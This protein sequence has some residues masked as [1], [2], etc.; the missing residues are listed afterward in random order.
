MEPIHHHAIAGPGWAYDEN[1]E[2]RPFSGYG[3]SSYGAWGYPVCAP[4]RGRSVIPHHVAVESREDGER[5]GRIFYGPTPE[6]L[7]ARRITAERA[8]RPVVF[9]MDARHAALA[10]DSQVKMVI[11]RPDAAPSLGAP[12]GAGART[13]PGEAN[14]HH[15]EL[16][17]AAS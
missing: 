17:G 2:Y 15:R 8:R 13:R 16:V 10:D 6:Q 4:W 5:N 7:A 12:I 9:R 1:A 3:Q 14:G 11:V